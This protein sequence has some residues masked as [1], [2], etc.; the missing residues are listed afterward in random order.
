MED[1]ITDDDNAQA[2][3]SNSGIV[4]NIYDS[5]EVTIKNWNLSDGSFKVIKR[6]IKVLEF[7][8]Y[9]LAVSVT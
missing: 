4:F 1:S 3:D 9:Q 2:S 5:A 7:F 8:N 6:R